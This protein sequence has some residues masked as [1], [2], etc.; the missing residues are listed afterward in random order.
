M[1]CARMSVA[2]ACR[3]V[4]VALATPITFGSYTVPSRHIAHRTPARRRATATTAR[5]LPRRSA[6]AWAQTLIGSLASRTRRMLHAARTPASPPAREPPA[7]T[8]FVSPWLHPLKVWSLQGTRGGSLERERIR[9][10]ISGTCS[11]DERFW[12]EATSPRRHNRRERV[13]EGRDR[14]AR[15]VGARDNAAVGVEDRDH[16][17]V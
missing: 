6:R 9:P 7:G 16:R 14:S 2:W 12:P 15:V 5:R 17:V 1:A 4:P 10:S 11:R 3:A 13:R 8:C